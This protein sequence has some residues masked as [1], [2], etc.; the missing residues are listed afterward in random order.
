MSGFYSPYD[1]Y[2]EYN[3]VTFK[4]YYNRLCP[5]FQI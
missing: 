4:V 2:N 5:N 3:L 1:M